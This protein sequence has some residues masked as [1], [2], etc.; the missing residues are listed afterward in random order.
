MQQRKK[1]NLLFSYQFYRSSWVLFVDI[2]LIFWPFIN[3]TLNKRCCETWS[4]VCGYCTYGLFLCFCSLWNISQKCQGIMGGLRAIS[5]RHQWVKPTKKSQIRYSPT[6]GQKHET[7]SDSYPIKN[8][9]LFNPQSLSQARDRR[10]KA[11][12]LLW[13]AV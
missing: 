7:F 5:C 8:F 9:T 13:I 11:S 1:Y 2:F 4:C 12:L 10:W 3:S 6:S